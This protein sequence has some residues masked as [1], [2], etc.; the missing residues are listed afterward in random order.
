MNNFSKI[1]MHAIGVGGMFGLAM[2]IIFSGQAYAVWPLSI[3]ILLT[4]L[5]CSARLIA[6]DHSQEDLILGLII[7]IG[8][9]L[10]AWWL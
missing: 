10:F 9:Q 6:S 5:V 1:S 2:I 8:T 4:G 7:G 3:A